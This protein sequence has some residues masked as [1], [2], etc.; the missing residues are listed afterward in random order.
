MNQSI[1]KI[2]NKC[3]MTNE[4]S[5][6]FC[7]KCGNNLENVKVRIKTNNGA[8]FDEKELKVFITTDKVPEGYITVGVIFHHLTFEYKS[9]DDISDKWTMLMEN[10][11]QTV[12][13][14]EIN[15][16]ANIKFSTEFHDTQSNVVTLTVTGD[17]IQKI[18]G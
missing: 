6:K 10:V 11:V 8:Y 9:T 14:Q 17:G 18:G 1:Y 12:E 2:C 4:G 5:A 15:G 7:T 13:A 16:A 3:G